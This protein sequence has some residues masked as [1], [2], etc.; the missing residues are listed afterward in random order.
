[1][2]FNDLKLQRE[3]LLEEMSMLTHALQGSLFERFTTCSRPSCS[4]HDGNRHGPRYYLVV[5]EHGHQRQKY[6][7]LD[8]VAAVKNGI[9]Q[10]NRMQNIIQELTQIN[11]KLMR[12]KYFADS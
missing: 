4:C 5:Y 8:Q 12:K 7:P 10:Y 3:K 2:T 6:V 1:M 9:R 11:V